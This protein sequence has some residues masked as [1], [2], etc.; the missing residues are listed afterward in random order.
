[1]KKKSTPYDDVYR[2]MM[3]DCITLLI[4]LVN[5]V[6]GKHYT[7]SEKIVFRP[8]EH[9]I[10][11]QDGHEQ[12]RITDSSFSIISNDG[13]EE[14]FI[15]ECQSKNDDTMLIRIF[16][17]ITQEALDSGTVSN[18]QL[19]VTI[20]NAAVLF[21]RSN[22]N[23]PDYMNIII[24]TPGGSVSFDVHII[25][26]NA[27]SLQ[28][29]FDK[30]LFFLLPFYI[31]NLEDD[32]PKFNKDKKALESLKSVYVDFMLRLENAVDNGL[33][34]AYYRRTILDMSKKVLENL[35]AKYKNVKKGVSDIMG[36]QVLEHEGKTIYNAGIKEGIAV[37]EERWRREEKLDTARRLRKMGLSDNDI[38]QATNLSLDDIRIL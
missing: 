20:P 19:I 1:M 7:G 34:S 33:I 14:K 15:I 4:P 25:K 36:G 35:A 27:Y 17:Y 10:N 21:L 23:T 2:T 29:L 22:S 31:F 32:F 13:S 38:H 28:Q 5:E 6:F 12:K 18:Y 9:F 16:E 11:Q 37:S 3:N 26:V 8:N 30:N 24:N